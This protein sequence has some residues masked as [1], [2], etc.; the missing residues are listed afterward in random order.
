MEEE[1]ASPHAFSI[2]LNGWALLFGW[3][4]PEVAF[5]GLNRLCLVLK[6]KAR[7]VLLSS[8]AEAVKTLHL[9]GL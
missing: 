4:S 2:V 9:N 6:Q 1:V 7:G 5:E 3:F 8:S